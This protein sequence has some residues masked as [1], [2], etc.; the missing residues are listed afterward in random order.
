M[1][2]IVDVGA[3]VI[4]RSDGSFLLA[5]RPAGKVYAGYWEFPGGKIEPGENPLQGLARELHEELGIEVEFA[6][7]W[8]TQIFTYPHAKVRL[9]FYRVTVWR[10]EPRG[11]ENQRIAW[12]RPG[13]P[14]LQPM[15]PAN[16]P[17]FRALQL[18]ALYAISNAQ[19]LGVEPYLQRLQTALGNGL[20]LVQL[21][22]NWL[23][24]APL[25]RLAIRVIS[26]CR[27]HGA[28]VLINSD[29]ALATRVGAEGLHLTARQL[30][31]LKARPPNIELLAA[32]C[33][34]A[35]ELAKAIALGVDLVALGP[36]QRT[37]SHPEATPLGWHNF[38][39]L[40]AAS[41][42]PVYAL[43]GLTSADLA[44]AQQHGAHGIAMQR[45]AW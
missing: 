43:G 2:P 3:A 41:P 1:T 19:E 7:P 17:V 24:E 22:E 34:D 44:I 39:R 9:H 15:L 14:P 45:A 23:E 30:M 31:Q 20:K 38:S 33:H 27:G 26:H 5:E 35:E 11:R 13:E 29:A 8:L 42:L 16:T 4:T 37:R 21:R 18:P 36:V 32:S 40:I 12:Q 25:E 28:K 10:G 6:S